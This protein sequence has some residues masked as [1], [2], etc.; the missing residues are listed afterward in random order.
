MSDVARMDVNSTEFQAAFVADM[1]ELCGRGEIP[2]SL[3]PNDWLVLLGHAQL[4]LRHPQARSQ[5]SAR[6]GEVVRELVHRLGVTDIIRKGLQA[7]SDPRHD[8]EFPSVRGVAVVRPQVVTLCG[9]TKFK[10]A[11][12]EANFRET[13]LGRIV[14]SVGL[15]GH[16]DREVYNP[17]PE[18]KRALDELHFRKIDLSDMVLFLNVDDY[19]G[20]SSLNELDYARRLGKRVR[21]L[22]L[23]SKWALPGEDR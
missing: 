18:E 6:A 9:S 20:V 2:I 12:I 10:Q 23:P 22:N 13:M 16:A 7:G 17:T 15:Y 1:L 11:F 3:S 8:T 14:L 21:W 5:S 4:G 19:L